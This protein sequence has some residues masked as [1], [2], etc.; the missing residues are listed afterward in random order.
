MQVLYKT[1]LRKSLFDSH[2]NGSSIQPTKKIMGA[3]C[4]ILYLQPK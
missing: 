1:H 3:H 2:Y 4:T